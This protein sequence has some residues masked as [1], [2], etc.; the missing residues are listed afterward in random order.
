M[1]CCKTPN[2]QTKMSKYL[3]W[4]GLIKN[5]FWWLVFT[6]H[7][8]SLSM[9]YFVWAW[10]NLGN[11]VCWNQNHSMLINN[12]FHEKREK[13]FNEIKK[14]CFYELDVIIMRK[15]VFQ[16]DKNVFLFPFYV[17]VQFWWSC[18]SGFS[19]CLN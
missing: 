9:H 18:I 10:I 1:V 16:R 5:I 3:I 15:G 19:E 14:V 13:E 7:F 12:N 4:S 6:Q 17:F 8:P 11:R 2:N